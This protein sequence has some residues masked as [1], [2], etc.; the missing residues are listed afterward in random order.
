ML[1]GGKGGLQT[2]NGRRL[3]S[4]AF[5]NL[6]LRKA[7]VV[8]RLKKLVKE[9]PFLAFNA[10]DLFPDAWPAKQLRDNLIMSSHLWPAMGPA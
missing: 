3:S 8:P 7:C 6:R 5:R 2:C 9:F 1:S 10:L 4:H